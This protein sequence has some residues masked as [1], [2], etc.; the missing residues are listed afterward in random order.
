MRFMETYS[1]DPFEE[2]T[3]VFGYTYQD[4]NEL[5]DIYANDHRE[6]RM[7]KV[8]LQ[9]KRREMQAVKMIQ[10]GKQ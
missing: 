4:E 10:E 3:D 6:R 1:G 9:Q 7:D 8:E 2:C 5:S